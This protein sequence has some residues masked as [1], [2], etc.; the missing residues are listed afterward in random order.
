MAPYHL[1]EEA[2]RIDE[3]L[4]STELNYKASGV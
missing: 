4:V 3:K 2:L 1:V